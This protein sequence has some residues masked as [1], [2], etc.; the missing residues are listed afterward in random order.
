M[1]KNEIFVYV[2]NIVSNPW[3]VG[4]VSSIISSLIVYWITSKAFSK[5]QNKENLQKIGAANNE[6]LFAVRY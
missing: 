4:I 5:K 2:A 1:E 6:M 3:F